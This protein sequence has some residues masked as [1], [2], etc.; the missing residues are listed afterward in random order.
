M[1]PIPAD[2]LT[3]C[4]ADDQTSFPGIITQIEAIIVEARSEPSPPKYIRI[5]RAEVHPDRVTGNT[6]HYRDGAVQ[7]APK[8]VE[9]VKMPP[10]AGFYLLY[11][12]DAGNEMNDTYHESLDRAKEQAEF[13]FGTAVSEWELL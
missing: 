8:S 9:I 1:G 12:D 2:V 7:P 11:L 3:F 5:V 13:E 6:R 4:L 10:D